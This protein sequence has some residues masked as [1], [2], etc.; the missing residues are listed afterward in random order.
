MDMMLASNILGLTDSIRRFMKTQLRVVSTQDV[1]EH[2]KNDARL[3]ILPE[4]EERVYDRPRWQ[5]SVRR[6]IL[7][8][9]RN[10]EIKR[11]GRDQYILN[12][13]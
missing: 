7:Q 6:I 13:N 8:L 5:H 11:I 2:V 12:I 1:C 9:V 10:G 3:E 4:H